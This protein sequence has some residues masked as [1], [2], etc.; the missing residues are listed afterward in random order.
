MPAHRRRL[1]GEL[2]GARLLIDRLWLGS[3]PL[4]DVSGRPTGR[5]TRGN[6]GSSLTSPHR[7]PS[8]LL[9]HLNL[10]Q[11]ALHRLDLL[12]LLRD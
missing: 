12:R 5:P 1:C 4:H 2:P 7:T 6:A 11:P 10:I 9:H 8:R 3:R